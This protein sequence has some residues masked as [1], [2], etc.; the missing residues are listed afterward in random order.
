MGTRASTNRRRASSPR[1]RGRGF[2]PL[3][4]APHSATS[5]RGSDTTSSGRRSK[6]ARRARRTATTSLQRASTTCL[7]PP[8][9]TR[10]TRCPRSRRSRRRAPEV[11]IEPVTSVTRGGS[12]P[13]RTDARS[14]GYPYGG[15]PTSSTPDSEPRFEPTGEGGE[16]RASRGRD[17]RRRDLPTGVRRGAGSERRVDRV[18]G[19]MDSAVGARGGGGGCPSDARGKRSIGAAID[20]PKRVD[21]AECL[22]RPNR[23]LDRL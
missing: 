23:V 16:G 12:S 7:G 1:P 8:R 17:A 11:G 19:A 15:T 9:E 13:P 18:S 21:R 3:P 4:A 14:G 2:E 10:G 20:E 5:P 6:L 22:R